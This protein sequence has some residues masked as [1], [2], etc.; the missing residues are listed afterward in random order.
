VGA[1]ALGIFFIFFL[2]K[3]VLGFFFGSTLVSFVVVMSL[4]KRL[5]RH[6]TISWKYFSLS[7]FKKAL[8]YGL[9]LSI[10]EISHSLLNVGDRYIIQYYLDSFALGLYSGP[11]TLSMHVVQFID[12]PILLA[13]PVIYFE[14]WS[15]RGAQAVQTFLKDGLY[16]FGLI[17][18]PTIF[19]TIA[20]SKELL[21]FLA[22]DKF[23]SSSPVIPFVIVGGLIFASSTF[24]SAGLYIYKKTIIPGSLMLIS[25]LINLLLNFLLV[26]N[27]GIIGAAFATLIGYT[28]YVVMVIPASFKYL[29]YRPDFKALGRCLL[30]SSAMFIV[31]MQIHLDHGVVNLFAR[32]LIGCLIYLGFVFSFEIRVRKL[33]IGLVSR[34]PQYVTNIP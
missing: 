34:K 14:L 21:V 20:V 15:N 4:T 24:F 32:V 17:A 25:A 9:P 23:A 3:G 31:I 8:A 7:F 19:G 16:Y 1:V 5:C 11:Y 18:L 28:S 22:S 13:V 29:S 27:Y 12:Y 33:F 6:Q 2:I 10:L 26:P 30:Y